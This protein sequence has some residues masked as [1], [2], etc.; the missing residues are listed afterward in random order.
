M[1][2]SK[3]IYRKRM[4]AL[5]SLLSIL[6]AALLVFAPGNAIAQCNKLS[7]EIRPGVNFS[8]KDLG[9]TSLKTGVGAEGT[10]AYRFMPH[11]GVYAGWSWNRF[12][13]SQSTEATK[14]DFEETGYMYGLQF[15][16]PIADSRVS[17]M[18]KGGG[19]YN[20]IETENSE[21]TVINDTGH[22]TGWQVG[23]GASIPLGNRFNLVP[24]VRYRSLSRNFK[25]NNVTIPVDLNYISAGIGCSF[26]F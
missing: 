1:K 5:I 10:F 19:T 16:H 14:M 24:E 2:K 12:S 6:I 11:L 3:I 22:G 20:H 9:N 18:I 26:T 23:I 13:A 21:G 8:T 17:Y 15:I 7:F 25:S 4:A